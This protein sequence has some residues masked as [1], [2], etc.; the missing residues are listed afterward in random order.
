MANASIFI[1]NKIN[2]IDLISGMLEVRNTQINIGTG[3]DISLKDLSEMIKRQINYQGLIEFDATKP[4]GTMRK[5]LDVT[6]LNQLGW[7][8]KIE[9]E[10]GIKQILFLYGAIKD[11][12]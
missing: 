4:D 3:N 10:D 11:A 6:K 2:F 12:N 5:F 7:K 9:L 8:Y 1:M